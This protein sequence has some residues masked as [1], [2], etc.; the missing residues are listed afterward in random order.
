MYRQHL[1]CA[2]TPPRTAPSLLLLLERLQVCTQ[3]CLDLWRLHPAHEPVPVHVERGLHLLHHRHPEGNLGRL[4]RPVADAEHGAELLLGSQ[5]HLALVHLLVNHADPERVA[6]R[7]HHPL[8][9]QGLCMAESNGADQSLLKPRR[10]NK[11]EFGLIHAKTVPLCHHSVVA[12]DRK[13]APC[14]GCC[15]LN[16]G[17]CRQSCSVECVP[18]CLQGRPKGRQVV[19]FWL[20]H[21]HKVYPR[22][23][24][25]VLGRG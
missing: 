1:Q 19:C 3:A 14:C 12:G 25:L 7:H 10:G 20:M 9:K 23:E 11:P 2:R 16:G 4:P 24:H 15:P 18:E 17:H 21:H 22:A 8:E 13:Q 5:H 6:R